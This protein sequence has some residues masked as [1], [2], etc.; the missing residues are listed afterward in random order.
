MKTNQHNLIKKYIK[1]LVAGYSNS[2]IVVSPAGYGKTE[3]VLERMKELN[4]NE[5]SHYKYINN[6]ITPVELYKILE[7]MKNMKKPQILI[8]DDVEQILADKK[9]VGILK[10]ALWQMP[11][12]KRK[13]CWVSGTHK[14]DKQE[15]E[16]EG[17]IIFLLNEFSK[18][19]SIVGALKDRSFYYEMTM[20]NDEIIELLKKRIKK[21]YFNIPFEQRKKILKFIVNNITKQTNL[22]LRILPKAFQ[23]YLISPTDWQEMTIEMLK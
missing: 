18:K 7:E 3:L 8:L 12:G 22:S 17:K 13:V 11:N 2:L 21:P 4:Y 6:Y 20:S 19:K 5:N 14:I 23:T 10:S 9:I 15:F 16:F 1:G